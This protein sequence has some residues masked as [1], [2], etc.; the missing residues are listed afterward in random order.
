L[1]PAN[2]LTDHAIQIGSAFE[3]VL[4]SMALADR[5]RIVTQE[6]QRM[7]TAHTEELEARVRERTQALEEA[8]RR[9]AALSATDGLTGVFNR[10][11]FDQQLR[12]ECN[13]GARRGPLSVLMVDVD[14]FK[15]L[16]DTYGH[17]VG[18][19]CLIT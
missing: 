14:H 18:D 8:N 1:L 2:F 7:Q 3:V 15:R 9:L 11:H 13:R 16:N 4:L 5:L 12:L 17:Q 6:N 10:R 19:A